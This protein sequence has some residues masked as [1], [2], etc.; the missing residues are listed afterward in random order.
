MVKVLLSKKGYLGAFLLTHWLGSG[1]EPIVSHVEVVDKCQ[2]AY[3]VKRCIP[4]SGTFFNENGG[5]L[6]DW[7]LFE[8]GFGPWQSMSVGFLILLSSFL[9]S[10]FPF[11]FCKDQLICD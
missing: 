3:I 10:S 5:G 2:K 9:L 6:G 11:P 4:D 7:L 1:F 8:D